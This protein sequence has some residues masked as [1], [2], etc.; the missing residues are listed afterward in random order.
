MLLGVFP[1]VTLKHTFTALD[2]GFLMTKGN[3]MKYLIK[4]SLKKFC[5]TF[6]FNEVLI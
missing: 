1:P 6:Y 5:G 2:Y 3:T 4:T